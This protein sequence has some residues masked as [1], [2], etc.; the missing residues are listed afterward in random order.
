MTNTRLRK[1]IE[2]KAKVKIDGFYTHKDG[3]HYES[4]CCVDGYCDQGYLYA[5]AT[6]RAM[7]LRK[8]LLKVAY[9][10]NV[11]VPASAQPVSEWDD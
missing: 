7:A 8:T 1:L 9:Q 2:K 6:G 5:Y 4:S 11:D 10:L 3:D